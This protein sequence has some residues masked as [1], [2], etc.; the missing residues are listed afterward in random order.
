MA[1]FKKKDPGRTPDNDWKEVGYPIPADAKDKGYQSPSREFQD[2]GG[3][4]LLK[5]RRKTKKKKPLKYRP[6]GIKKK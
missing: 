6:G 5:E 4:L 3:W 2:M 1:Y